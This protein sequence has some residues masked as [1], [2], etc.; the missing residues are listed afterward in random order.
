MIKYKLKKININ[1]DSCGKAGYASRIGIKSAVNNIELGEIEICNTSIFFGD[2]LYFDDL[3]K[4]LGGKNKSVYLASHTHFSISTVS[5]SKSKLGITDN[6]ELSKIS[7]DFQNSMQVEGELNSYDYY[8]MDV[9]I[10]VYRRLEINIPL[11]NRGVCFPLPN[12][13]K[14][15][16]KKIRVFAFKNNDSIE[17]ILIHHANHPVTGVDEINMSSDYVGILRNAVSKKF[18]NSNVF[19]ML[20]AAGDVRPNLTSKRFRWLPNNFILNKKFCPS[21]TVKLRELVLDSYSNLDELKLIKSGRVQKIN[22][23]KE[24]IK[25]NGPGSFSFILDKM[26]FNDVEFQFWPF[27]VSNLYQIELN[28]KFP[29]ISKLI[30]SCSGNVF[31]YLPYKSQIHYGGYEVHRSRD[32]FS[33]KAEIYYE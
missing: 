4:Y 31:G 25:L 32:F 23:E 18:K 5:E 7:N 11:I 22:F 9:N 2:F 27:E 6:F 3:I 17:F 33:L 1:I 8:E 30:V 20:G 13:K 21:N 19:F 26:K 24:E 16:D 29:N 10:P 12:L 14:N 28:E 15:I